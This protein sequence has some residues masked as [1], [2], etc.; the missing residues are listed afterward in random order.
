MS[1]IKSILSGKEKRQLYRKPK[2][3]DY[4][5]C[6]NKSCIWCRDGRLFNTKKRLE[7]YNY[8]EE[9]VVEDSS[10]AIGS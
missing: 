2:A 3:Y 8:Q 5:C 1:L 4:S 9:L 10:E 6:N 7:K